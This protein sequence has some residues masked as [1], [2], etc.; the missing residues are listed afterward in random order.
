MAQY[1]KHYSQQGSERYQ[2]RKLGKHQAELRLVDR[3][4]A[5]IPQSHQVLDCPCG[6]GRLTVHLAQRGYT[7]TGADVSED[8]VRIAH[9]KVAEN[10]LA[11]PIGVQDL[12][13]LTYADGDFDTLICFRLFHHFPDAEIR[14]RVINE[15]CRV[16]GHNVV[17]SY[18]SPVSYT[19]VV[20]K[21]RA[22]AGGRKP[23]K[24]ATS[25][26]EVSGYFQSNGFKLVQDFAQMPILHTLHLAV[27]ERA[28]EQGHPPGH[29]PRKRR[30]V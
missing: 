23:A 25:L 24:Y 16:A 9:E 1:R 7:V 11:C 15:L 28:P 26:R 30:V 2:H 8:M 17:L 18:F 5:L 21:L 4:L 3:A 27:F 13:K 19:S 12:E 10:Q 14:R 22:A 29:S 20:R 6:G